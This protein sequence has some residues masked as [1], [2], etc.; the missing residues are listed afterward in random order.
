[1]GPKWQL[2]I[3]KL[4]FKFLPAYLYFSVYTPVHISTL[5]FGLFT[6]EINHTIISRPYYDLNSSVL[7]G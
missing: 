4:Q 1:M 7:S 5:V 2:R 3:Y 6:T